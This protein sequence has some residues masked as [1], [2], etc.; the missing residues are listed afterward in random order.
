MKRT[1]MRDRA[2]AIINSSAYDADT[3]RAV[4]LS[5]ARNDAADLRETVRRAE[6]GD[7]ICDLTDPLLRAPAPESVEGFGARLRPLFEPFLADEDT[8]SREFAESVL[9]LVT[10]AYRDGGAPK[11]KRALG[12]L[13][14]M[15]RAPDKQ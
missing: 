15:I 4:E 14:R 3:R 9:S 10:V 12:E 1:T 7:T 8:L 13:T 6:A 5:L 2:E 11:A